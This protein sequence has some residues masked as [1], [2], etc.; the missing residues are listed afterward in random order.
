MKET[1][2]KGEDPAA[3]RRAWMVFP[4]CF[5]VFLSGY[6]NSRLEVKIEDK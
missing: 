2:L 5:C 1:H 6:K 3:G 4:T